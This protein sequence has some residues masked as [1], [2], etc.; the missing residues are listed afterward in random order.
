M[1]NSVEA[2][3]NFT[4]TDELALRVVAYNHKQ[5]GW[6]D[7]ILNKPGQGGY[8][9]SAVVIDRIS[10][11][12]LSGPQNTPIVSPENSRLVEDDTKIMWETGNDMKSK[13]KET[14][15]GGLAVNIIEC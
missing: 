13:Y 3:I 11:G 7:N 6:I 9:G 8:I 1:S 10:G 4:P 14:S 2:F 12:V 5:G 15:R